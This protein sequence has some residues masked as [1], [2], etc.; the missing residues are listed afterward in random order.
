MSVSERWSAFHNRLRIRCVECYNECDGDVECAM[1]LL[2]SRRVSYGFDVATAMLL[3]QLALMLFKW[4]KDNG[5]LTE[6]PQVQMADEPQLDSQ[7]FFDE[8]EE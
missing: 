2:R 8:E 7:R 6:L 1:K 3:M 4:A 5:Y